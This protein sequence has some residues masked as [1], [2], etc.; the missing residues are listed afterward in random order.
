MLALEKPVGGNAVRYFI[1]AFAAF[2]F[3]AVLVSA[4][5]VPARANAFTDFTAATAAKKAGNLDTAIR[6]YT[7][8]IQS[9][10]FSGNNLAATHYNRANTYFAMR[11]FDHAIVDFTRAIELKPNYAFA[12]INRGTAY[13]EKRQYD[14][15]IADQTTAIKLKPDIPFAYINRGNAYAAKRQYDRA[16]ADYTRAIEIKRDYAIPYDNRAKAH[17]KKGLLKLA[18]RD[19]RTALRLAPKNPMYAHALKRLGATP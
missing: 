10:E 19:Y 15:A 13:E 18:I 16:I 17:E 3:V 6:L 8:V 7:R 5:V 4:P 14:R 12:Y 1:K 9:G 2:A 11:R